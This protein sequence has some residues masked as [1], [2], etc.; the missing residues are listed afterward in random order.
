MNR[1]ATR[2]ALAVAAV[3]GYFLIFAQF[4]FVEILRAG[5]VGLTAEKALLGLMAAAGIGGGFIIAWRGVSPLSVRIA[6][7]LAGA[8][9]ALST[10]V[11]GTAAF[12][13][14]ALATGACL[15]V[16][17]VGLSALLPA[18]CGVAWV[19]LG[20]GMGYALCNVP[21][22]FMQSPAV[23]AWVGAGFAVAGALALPS[24]VAWP[25]KTTG[26]KVFPM[27]GAVVMFTA[28][29]WMDSAAFF[30]IQHSTDLKSG[31]WGEPMLWR[32]S[33][34]H[35]SM[36]GAAGIWLARGG[37]RYL[38]GTAWV[39]LAV[40]ALAVN[41]D[42]TR[43]IA[44]W[45]YPVGVSLYSAA[46][47]A[48]PGWFSGANDT[49]TAAWRAAWLFA[50]AGWFGS[51]NGIGMA[52]TLE[53]VPPF[54][55]AGAG[56]LVVAVM[57]L[58]NP[59]RWR[60]A[61]AVTGVVLACGFGKTGNLSVLPSAA[62]R[63]RQVYVSEGCIHCHS[64]YVRPGSADELFWGP[65]PDMKSVLQGEP[66]LI[67]NRRQGP[68]LTNVGARRS[69]AW[70][71]EHFMD[72]RALVPGSPMPSYAHLFDDG[73]GNDLV[74][75]LKESGVG[76]TGAVMARAAVWK[77]GVA[78]DGGGRALFASHCAVCHG[79]GGHGD[80]ILSGKFLRPPANLV[81]G[82]FIWTTSGEEL[83]T[84]IAR[85]IRFGITGTDMPGHEV[86]TDVQVSAL[87]HEVLRLRTHSG[88]P[89]RRSK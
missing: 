1:L 47:V 67:G 61:L 71:R 30:I 4:A 28:L 27:W 63:G 25:E 14:I 12:V 17:T 78:A 52:E 83:E 72:P 9:A 3:Y 5:G 49:R 24:T 44:G 33:L 22:V 23:Q 16:A 79:D 11:S 55:V 66:V 6:L 10:V 51:A 8:V 37:A 57:L 29:V 84:R 20:T 87:V 68:D 41:G 35:F 53:R 15:G 75:Y 82:P 2:A 64:Q 60:V 70:L 7:A 76:A 32:N 46:L 74:R 26:A 18:W 45:F 86:M 39:L 65:P 80:G 77:T 21:A 88:M 89:E 38:P 81:A 69:E 13:V 56:V 62:E 43:G 42:D 54:F 59:G 40:A 50:I 48:W 58:A 36:A 34:L 73:R 31:T 19:G 85:V